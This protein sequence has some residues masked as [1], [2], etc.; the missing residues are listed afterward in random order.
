MSQAIYHSELPIDTL[1][2]TR[3]VRDLLDV[4]DRQLRRLVAS[5]RFPKPDARLGRALKSRRSAV[6]RFLNELTGE[7]WP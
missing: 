2:G 7:T 6:E 3:R 4:S 5:G 1:L